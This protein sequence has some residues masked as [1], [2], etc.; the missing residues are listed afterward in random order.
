MS[1]TSSVQMGQSRLST[2]HQDMES[3]EVSQA[4][5]NHHAEQPFSNNTTQ[6]NREG[7]T[8]RKYMASLPLEEGGDPV[9]PWIMGPW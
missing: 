8:P 9:A 2:Y 7:E 6:G 4:S 1:I 5:L 3:S